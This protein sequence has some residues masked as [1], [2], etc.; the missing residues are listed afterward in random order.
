M[1]KAS[2]VPLFYTRSGGL[3][4]KHT[5]AFTIV[6]THDSCLIYMS[7]IL[8]APALCR[9]AVL[10]LGNAGPTVMISIVHQKLEA[11]HSLK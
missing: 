1:F 6:K 5:L 8:Q 4:P 3:R 7:Q 2:R 9:I 11:N 10:A